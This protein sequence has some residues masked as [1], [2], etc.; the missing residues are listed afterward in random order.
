[1]LGRVWRGERNAFH[2]ARYPIPT[3]F[4]AHALG[5]F[6]AQHIDQLQCQGIAVADLPASSYYNRLLPVTL[7]CF[8]NLAKLC[9]LLRSKQLNK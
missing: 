6:D 4:P 9:C 3:M 1:M 2:R 7:I 5:A 8:A